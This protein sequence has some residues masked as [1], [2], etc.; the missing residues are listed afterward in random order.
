VQSILQS[1]LVI[2]LLTQIFLQ[3]KTVILLFIILA[4]LKVKATVFVFTELI[5]FAFHVELLLF[6]LFTPI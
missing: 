2:V 3:G 6:F 1:S 4:L 5:Y